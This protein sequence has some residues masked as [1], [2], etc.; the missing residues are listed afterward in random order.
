[1]TVI[2]ERKRIKQTIDALNEVLRLRVKIE[3]IITSN[4]NKIKKFEQKMTDSKDF[5]YI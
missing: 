4:I 1:M 5:T 2:N 3:Q